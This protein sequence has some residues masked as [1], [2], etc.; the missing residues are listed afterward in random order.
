MATNDENIKKIKDDLRKSIKKPPE[1]P[2]AIE[3]AIEGSD[4]DDDD[5]EEEVN[6]EPPEK[7]KSKKSKSKSSC[8]TII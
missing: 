7:I 6:S 1:I 2:G 8:C 5:E 4:S 3:P